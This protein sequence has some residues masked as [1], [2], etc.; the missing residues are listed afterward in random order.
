MQ[1]NRPVDQLVCKI[2]FGLATFGLL[3]TSPVQVGHAAEEASVNETSAVEEPPLSIP[4]NDTLRFVVRPT[5]FGL[6]PPPDPANY[7]E[8][9]IRVRQVGENGSLGLYY[10]IKEEVP[11]N[12]DGETTTSHRKPILQTTIR[13]GLIS[14]GRKAGK[15]YILPPLF[16]QNGD[17]NT[18]SGLLWLTRLEFSSLKL[19]SQ[20]AWD[21]GALE[22]IAQWAKADFEQVLGKL[23]G[24]AAQPGDS[25]TVLRVV[26]TS[27]SYPVVVNG[28]RVR[29]PAIKAHDSLGL[30]EYW[31]LDDPD[32]PLVLKLT[33]IS[34]WAAG[35]T[36]GTEGYCIFN[37]GGFAVVEINF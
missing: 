31:I 28:A 26:E 7:G 2:L 4:L 32:N 24:T 8:V 3:Q 10:E 33:Y 23:Q 35:G 18:A 20:T 16:W 29:L 12:P 5:L 34:N 1:H 19:N 6:V 14:V 37:G 15:S 17:F 36:A 13:R 9:F 25:R 27:A 30:A 22:G 21:I 11:R